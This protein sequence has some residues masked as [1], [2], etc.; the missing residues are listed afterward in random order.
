MLL[1]L[2][3]FTYSSNVISVIQATFVP[4]E[5]SYVISFVPR[6]IKHIPVPHGILV[7]LMTLKHEY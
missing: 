1:N 3:L 2:D 7:I 5:I 6:G 4:V